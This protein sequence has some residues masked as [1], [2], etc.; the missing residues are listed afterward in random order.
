MGSLT[1]PAGGKESTTTESSRSAS[2]PANA[3]LHFPKGAASFCTRHAI[4]PARSLFSVDR[5][6]IKVALSVG[7]PTSMTLA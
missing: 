3:V 7:Y 6:G 5:N 2:I 1:D 4:V